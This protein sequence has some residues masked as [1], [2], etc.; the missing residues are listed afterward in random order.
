MATDEYQR[1]EDEALWEL[2]EIRNAIHSDLTAK[3]YLKSINAQEV[4]STPGKI[5][6]KRGRNLRVV[7]MI[8]ERLCNC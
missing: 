5:L 2:H 3:T 4:C 1:D 7:R 8:Q 6:S